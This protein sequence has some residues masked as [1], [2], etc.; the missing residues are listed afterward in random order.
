MKKKKNKVKQYLELVRTKLLE[1]VL[2]RY[3]LH[4]EPSKQPKFEPPLIIAREQCVHDRAALL[5]QYC[6]VLC[7]AQSKRRTSNGS[8]RAPEAAPRRSASAVLGKH[9]PGAHFLLSAGLWDRGE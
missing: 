4:V 2:Q 8:S 6:H 1:H 9:H 7:F 5:V 3:T